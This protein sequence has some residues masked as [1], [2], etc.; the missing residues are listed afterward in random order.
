M[1]ESSVCDSCG[2]EIAPRLL[3]CP[4]CRSLV[5]ADRLRGLAADAEHAA[6]P[7]SALVAWQSA[8]ELLPTGSRQY[9]TIAGRIA[10]LGREVD[11][12]PLG[13]PPARPTPTPAP[14][15]KGWT[16]A[17][18]IGAVALMAWKLKTIALIVL[19]KGKLLLLGL[20]KAS[21]FT[22]M[23]LSVGVY[24]TAFGWRF[25]LGLVVSIYIHEMGHVAA[26]LRYGIKASTP[27]FI[28]GLGAI[29]RLR[30]VLTDPRQDARVGLAGP[31]WGL[32][33]AVAAYIVSLLT[34]LQIWAGIAKFGASVNLFNLM[35]L[36]P[37]DG[38]R[39]FRALTRNQRWLA[40]C[41]VAIAWS[42]TGDMMASGLLLL[43]LIVATL[44]ALSRRYAAVPDREGLITYVALIILLTLL[45]SIGG[46]IAAE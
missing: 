12:T 34:G 33:A 17:A 37:L 46:P 3:S 28:P 38:G 9:R 2:T 35:P 36:G 11:A 24:W 40:V 39:A 16:G 19:T 25:A 29:I 15:A 42:I 13:Q 7:T 21:T 45:S 1:S 30:Q 5:H 14:A 44:S 32:G 22:S 18:G 41:A 4:N 6:D 26:L 27:L 20:T 43:I 23:A 10:E 31:I 8:L